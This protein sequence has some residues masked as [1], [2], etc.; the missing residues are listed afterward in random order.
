MP[1]GVAAAAAIS[2]GAGAASSSAQKSGANKASKIQ[3]NVQAEQTRNLYRALDTAR[4]SMEPYMGGGVAAQG[5]LKYLMGFA[6]PT[7]PDKEQFMVSSGVD[8]KGRPKPKVLDEAGWHAALQQYEDEKAN[9]YGAQSIGGRGSLLAPYTME[10]YKSDPGYTPMVNTLEEL[11]ATPGY[12]F[13]LQQGEQSAQRGAAA[14]GNMLSGAAQKELIRFGQGLASTSFQDAWN[15]AQ[16]AY[17]NA[18]N[19]NQ[20]QKAATFGYLSGMSGSGQNA[21]S[22]Y[23][24]WAVN[25]GR[26][27]NQ[28]L[29]AFGDTMGTLAL[30]N[31]AIDAN[32]YQS[33]GDSLSGAALKS[34]GGG[35]FSGLDAVGGN[36]NTAQSSS[37]IPGFASASAGW[38]G[39]SR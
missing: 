36:A 25:T 20:S 9:Y 6:E 17:Q 30:R 31:A 34:T 21:A 12:Q 1:W 26:D 8:R 39:G 13:Q 35:G 28:A 11:Q 33:L 14:R 5:T 27:N 4:T 37:Q 2:A 10:Q 22:N 7:A 23:G 18:F 19:R 3:S 32:Q 16:S 38:G 24:N 15:R 29:G